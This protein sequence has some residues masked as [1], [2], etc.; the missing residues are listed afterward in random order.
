MLTTVTPYQK[1]MLWLIGI[2]IVTKII[3][4][5][6]IELGNDEVY[7]YTYAVQPD[8]NHFDHPGMV[9]WMIRLTSL[10]LYWVSAL[11]MRLGSII[12][13]AVATYVIYKTGAMIKD[14]RAGYIYLCCQ[15]VHNYY[16]LQ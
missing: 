4:S 3:L 10:N 9:G 16:S 1:K 11:S 15:I 12:C 13:A 8:W 7:Y 5:F 6:F 14:Q 2:S